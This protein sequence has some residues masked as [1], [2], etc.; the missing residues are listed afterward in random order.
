M[1]C[2][3][4]QSASALQF[5]FYYLG[6]DVEKHDSK[7]ASS[8]LFNDACKTAGQAPNATNRYIRFAK[9]ACVEETCKLTHEQWQQKQ[10][11]MLTTFQIR[12]VA[13]RK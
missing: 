8:K 7:P 1:F 3:G 9:S 13:G 5:S 12:L 2:I 11:M 6:Y 10:S 4:V